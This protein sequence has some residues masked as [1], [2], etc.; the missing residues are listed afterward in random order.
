MTVSTLVR[1]SAVSIVSFGSCMSLT[2][3]AD[4]DAMCELCSGDL[5][6]RANG[7]VDEEHDHRE[8]PADCRT[9]FC[10]LCRFF[11]RF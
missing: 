8:V 1:D 6:E 10:G 11:K 5:Q 4:T 7:H 9:C 2:F 3:G